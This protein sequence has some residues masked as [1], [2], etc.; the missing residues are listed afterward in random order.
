[1]AHS[2]R[3]KAVRRDPRMARYRVHDRVL[4]NGLVDAMTLALAVIVAAL[5]AILVYGVLKP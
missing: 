5:F 3:P 1:M 2:P 4:A